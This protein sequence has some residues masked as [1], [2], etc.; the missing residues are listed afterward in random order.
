MCSRGRCRFPWAHQDYLRLDD[1]TV[2]CVICHRTRREPRRAHRPGHLMADR[3]VF[4]VST[5]EVHVS[6]VLSVAA[7]VSKAIAAAVA[8]GAAAYSAAQVAG[9]VDGGEWVTVLVAALGAGVVAYFAPK[10]AEA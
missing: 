3:I 4:D 2:E 6:K 8:A 7:R 9:S 10:N 5:Q 1:W